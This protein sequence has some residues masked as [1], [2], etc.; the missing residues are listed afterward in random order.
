MRGVNAS[1]AF[2][3]SGAA[4]NSRMSRIRSQKPS[5]RSSPAHP[6]RAPVRRTLKS[7]RSGQRWSLVAGCP[8]LPRAVS[9]C[10]V[11]AATFIHVPV[12]GCFTL[13]LLER[14]ARNVLHAGLRPNVESGD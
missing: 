10:F 3:A 1:G 11:P 6:W 7:H 5:L 12:I 8:E 2:V 9:D 14:R 13:V 4:T